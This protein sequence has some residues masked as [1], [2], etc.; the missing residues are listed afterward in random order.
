MR[1]RKADGENGADQPEEPAAATSEGAQIRMV[2]SGGADEVKKQLGI[3]TEKVETKPE[4]V[5]EDF[6]KFSN[7]LKNPK[8][9]VRVK[10]LRPKQWKGQKTAVE[11]WT[12][13]LPL[14]WEEIKAEVTEIANGGT[15]KVSVVNPETGGMIDARNFEID[16]DPLIEK[17]ELS[18]AEKAMF[19]P[20]EKDATEEGIQKLESRARFS[21]KLLEVESIEDQ[22]R[23]ARERRDGKGKKSTSEDDSRV[24]RLERNL[25]EA[26]HQAELES[27]DRKHAE[28]MRELKALIAAN[29]KPAQQGPSEV[30]L[31]IQQMQKNQ[32]SADKRFESLQKQLQDDRMNQLV[33][34]ID[35]L[36]KRPNKESG[37]FLDFAES[38]IKMKKLFGWGA[39]ADDDDEEEDDPN[40]DR[41]WW[42]KALDRLGDK[43]TPRVID[44]IFDRLDGLE[45]SG[46]KVDKDDFTKSLEIEMKKA[47]DEAVRIATERAIKALPQSKEP[48]PPKKE[49]VPQVNVMER[50]VV[51]E[52]EAPRPA[53][54]LPTEEKA[55]EVTVEDP[56]SPLHLVKDP[57]AAV[58]PTEAMPIAKEICLRVCNVILI[59]E[60][61]LET[62]P[63]QF[64]WN[65]EGAWNMLPE[66]VLEKVCLSKTPAEVFDA[67]K[68]EGINVEDLDKMKEKVISAPRAAAWMSRGISELNR[69]WKKVEADPDFDPAD[70]GEGEEAEEEGGGL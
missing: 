63:R 13:E 52:P 3:A 19:A 48:P 37:G 47:E 51:G 30:T 8:Y 18:D 21:Q 54:P 9:M 55:T 53:A 65:Y 24:E 67:F 31:L 36:E 14:Q 46:K 29:N 59:L 2:V 62:R 66:A 39:G 60:R 40:D 64:N 16:G 15:Y 42:Q 10:R 23:E 58:A 32:E 22:L 1:R 45:T 7:L 4:P 44:K 28:E 68:V 6:E 57:P 41:P 38:A 5:L 50:K 27:R 56:K 49:V 35:N 70:E 61:E 12:S 11:V 25:M 34:K 69:W 17:I 26:K 33:Q 43:L 20:Q